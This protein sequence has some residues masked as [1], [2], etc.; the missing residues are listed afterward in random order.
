MHSSNGSGLI[1]L[2]HPPASRLSARIT[3]FL[4]RQRRTSGCLSLASK[5]PKPRKEA[6]K[7]RTLPDALR[8]ATA[9]A[10][11]DAQRRLSGNSNRKTCVLTDAIMTSGLCYRPRHFLTAGIL[12]PAV[13]G[14]AAG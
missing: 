5:H 14:P 9:L 7:K 6:E 1:S 4:P 13:R 12:F 10:T 8:P 2:A 11:I 3:D